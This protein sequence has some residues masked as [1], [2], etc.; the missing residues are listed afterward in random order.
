MKQFVIVLDNQTNE[1]SIVDKSTR[2]IVSNVYRYEPIASGDT[3]EEATRL[4]DRIEEIGIQ[5]YFDEVIAS[6]E[7]MSE[8]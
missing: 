5:A 7:R 6:V 1:L 4:K 3:L 2:D 8:L